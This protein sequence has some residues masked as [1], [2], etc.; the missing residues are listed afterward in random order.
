MSGGMRFTLEH[1]NPRMRE[2][3]EAKL[4]LT[5]LKPRTVVLC[6]DDTEPAPPQVHARKQASKNKYRAIRVD[7]KGHRF[8]SRHEYEQYLKLKA[9]EG[10][11]EIEG[12]RTQVKFSLFDAGGTCRGEHI[13]TYR[14]DF[15]YREAGELRV[16]DA[17]SKHTKRLRDW[18]RT[19]ALMRACHGIEVI[20]L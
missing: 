14:A 13:G 10:A 9:R 7:I 4:R 2:Q 18:P 6:P 17:K 16:A 12:L 8:D 15:V 5:D 20:E 19:K 1:L 11:G 3:A